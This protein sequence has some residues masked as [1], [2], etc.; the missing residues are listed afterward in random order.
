MNSQ[1]ALD[2]VAESVGPCQPHSVYHFSNENCTFNRSCT[3]MRSSLLIA[4]NADTFYL[5][6]SEDP[7]SYEV[8]GGRF[9]RPAKYA[10]SILCR[11]MLHMSI[12]FVYIYMV[13]ANFPSND[14][15][16]AID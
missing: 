2:L 4:N 15:N 10:K 13:D 6:I 1:S 12:Y 5:F 8:R 11:D 14:E 16:G 7:L 3:L 9:I